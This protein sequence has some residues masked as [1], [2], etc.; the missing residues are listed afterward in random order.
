MIT[1]RCPNIP[2]SKIYAFDAKALNPFVA[3]EYIDGEPLSTIWSHYT[4]AEKGLVTLKITEI[5]VD[6]VE[7]CFSGIG[8]FASGSSYTLGPTV[9][10]SK[11]FKGCV[12]SSPFA[13]ISLAI[14]L[15]LDR[16]NFI[17]I[18]AALSVHTKPQRHMFLLV[19]TKIYTTIH[20][21][22]CPILTLT[23][24]NTHLSKIL[25]SSYEIKGSN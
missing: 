16:V 15:Y 25:C 24:S 5:I 2:V 8:G 6:M 19:M 21:P 7:M 1:A 11:L 22:P 20:M 4:Q 10:G 23:F 14:D 18:D 3:Q 17:L 9:E 13:L 12:S